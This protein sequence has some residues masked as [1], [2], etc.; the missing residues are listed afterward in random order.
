MGRGSS[1]ASGSGASSGK[2]KTQL[3]ATNARSIDNMNEAQLDK[4]IE[5]TKA[6]INRADKTMDNNDIVNTQEA[7]A[8]QEAFPLGVGGDG[9]SEQR[10]RARDKGLERD[11]KKAKAFT[12]AYSQKESAETRLKALEKAKEKVKGTDKTLSEIKSQEVK[13]QVDSTKATLTWKTTQ[14][15]GW[16]SSGGYAPKIIKAGNIEIHGSSG[17]YTIFRDGVRVGSTDKL[18]TAKA[19]AERIKKK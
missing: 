12:E 8:M 17:L 3:K 7:K 6:V 11:A 14:K 13:R 18:S 9:W 5:K 16:T 10:K 19:F 2:A 1:K 4:E 15:G